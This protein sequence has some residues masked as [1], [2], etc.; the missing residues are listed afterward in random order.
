[1]VNDP[2]LLFIHSATVHYYSRQSG[3][4]LTKIGRRQ[5]NIDCSQV[6]AQ[7]IHVAR[8]WNWNDPWFLR[9]KPCKV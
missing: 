2:H 7:V 3:F 1:L 9:K 6:L 4:D 5:L 8:T